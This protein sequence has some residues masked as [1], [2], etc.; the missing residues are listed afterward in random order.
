MEFIDTLP[1]HLRHPEVPYRTHIKRKILSL[2][3]SISA[4]TKV[5]L[6]TKFW[7]D[8]RNV[9][10]GRSIDANLRPLLDLLRSL[11][12]SGRVI[13][14]IST[15]IFLEIFRQSDPTTLAASVRLIDQLSHGICLL[16]EHERIGTE[17]GHFFRTY[18][19]G[20]DKIYPLKHLVWTKVAYVFGL[21]TPNYTNEDLKSQG[22]DVA[23]QKVFFD[24][25]WQTDLSDFL[26][27]SNGKLRMPDMPD[28]SGS[29]N[30]GKLSNLQEYTSFHDLFLIELKGVLDICRPIFADV[31]RAIYQGDTGKTP[32]DQEIAADKS[33]DWI[34]NAIYECFRLGKVSDELPIL[35]V[36]S[37]LHAAVR[38]DVSRKYKRN[39]CADFRH[40]TAAVPYYD[41]FLTERSLSLLLSDGNMKL[42]DYFGCVALPDA[43]GAFAVLSGLQK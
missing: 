24:E 29:L 20:T 31:M 6:D 21:V 11:V 38:W 23:L 18:S 17:T 39:D 27:V 14:P 34:A 33:G 36:G 8:L 10:L 5:Y 15:E 22:L 16:N 28:I 43:E 35:R 40:A 7:V 3:E 2:G 4:L 30:D 25:M 19:G 13:C 41:Y 1:E 37:S 32:T 12:A 26:V 42:R 9:A